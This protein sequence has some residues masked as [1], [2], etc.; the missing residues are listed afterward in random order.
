MLI[1]Q[2]STSQTISVELIDSFPT[3]SQN[4]LHFLKTILLKILN[5]IKCQKNKVKMKMQA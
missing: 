1:V 3:E 4:S 5:R 2:T